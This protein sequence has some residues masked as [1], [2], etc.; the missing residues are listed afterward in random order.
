MMNRKLL[1][2]FTEVPYP[3]RANGVSVRYFP[4]ME[5]LSG[6]YDIDIILI[7]GTPGEQ[8]DITQLKRYCNNLWR[9]P[10]P[11]YLEHTVYENLSAK[12]KF[13]LP[14][15]PPISQVVNATTGFIKEMSEIL[16]GRRYGTVVWVGSYLS[17]YIFPLLNSFSSVRV[18]V[19]FI[20]SPTL[21]QQ[22][23][24]ER[25]M[26]LPLFQ[27]FESWKTV[28][29]EADMIRKT[30]STVYISEVDA[31]TVPGYMTPGCK[32]HVIPNGIYID[33]N[34]KEKLATIPSP[35]IGFL[36]NMS[37]FPNIDAV[38]W[39]YK[40]VYCPLRS[41]IPSLSL[42][43]IGR[44][45]VQLV[46]ELEAD[47]GVIVTGTVDDVWKYINSVDVFVFPLWIGGGLKNKILET[48]YAMRPVVTTPIGNEGIDAVPGRDI[49]INSDSRGFIDTLE[50]LVQSESERSRVG[51]AA[52]RY[53]KEKYSWATL[54]ERFE[55]VFVGNGQE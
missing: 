9:I 34:S 49:L 11:K 47:P 45:P 36:G 10:D 46:R 51:E 50:G 27:K 33:S 13:F 54:L 4:L 52:H 25:S 37:Y 1:F 32:R 55:E 30:S 16:R 31:A 14:W 39:L 2:V 40:E 43:I 3:V 12:V 29:W 21:W 7:N 38:Q 28:R 35:N 15:T 44:D 8:D 20:D 41:T 26:G 23:R 48:M 19:D 42:V 6:K 24:Y 17:P 53:V 18:V 5:Y 22:R